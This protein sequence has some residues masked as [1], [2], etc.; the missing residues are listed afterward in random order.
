MQQFSELGDVNP[1][2]ITLE[3][4]SNPAYIVISEHEHT[5][6]LTTTGGSSNGC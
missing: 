5:S 2:V 6:A 1:I 4:P 3:I